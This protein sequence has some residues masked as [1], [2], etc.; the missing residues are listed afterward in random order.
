MRLCSGR[1][2]ARRLANFIQTPSYVSLLTAL[3]FYGFTTQIPQEIC[4]SVSP[5]RRAVYAVEGF[6]FAY[7]LLK[8]SCYCGFE[9]RDD[10]FIARPE[11]ALCDSLHLASFGSYAFDADAIDRERF[12]R[13]ELQRAVEPFPQRT[14]RALTRFLEG[15]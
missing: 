10:I 15:G 5:I 3:S 1:R 9:R 4:E 8:P 7:F 6:R 11:K 12:D 2:A 14:R 13:K